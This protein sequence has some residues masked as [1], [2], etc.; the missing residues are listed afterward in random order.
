MFPLR[1]VIK[2]HI[3]VI[4]VPTPQPVIIETITHCV[5][6]YITIHETNPKPLSSLA[7]FL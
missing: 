6:R 3:M 7:K 5:V 4:W 2:Y 1:T